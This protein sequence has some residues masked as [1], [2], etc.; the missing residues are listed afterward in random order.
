MG[1]D[2]GAA[3]QFQQMEDQVLGQPAFNDTGL[4]DQALRIEDA[5]RQQAV[6]RPF[7]QP[8]LGLA[9]WVKMGFIS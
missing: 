4:D 6:A 2:E 1:M 9:S 8:V 3:G 5:Q 7:R